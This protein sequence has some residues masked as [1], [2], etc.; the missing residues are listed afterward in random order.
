MESSRD[1]FL[2]LQD[3]EYLWDTNC[4]T[5]RKN[6]LVDPESKDLL[7]GYTIVGVERAYQ[8]Y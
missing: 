5:V 8:V 7:H 4:V 1:Q 6:G 3:P 2:Q